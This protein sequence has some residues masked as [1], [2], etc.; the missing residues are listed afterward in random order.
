MEKIAI[1]LLPLEII[2]KERHSAKLIFVNK[3][4][5][6]ILLSLVFL[7]SSMLALRILQNSQLKAASDNLALA[8]NRVLNLKDKEGYVITLKSRLNLIQSLLG[9]SK[10]ESAFNLI[11]GLVPPGVNPNQISVDKS[12]NIILSLQTNSLEALDKFILDLS[13][14]QKN[15]NLVIRVDLESFSRGKE[16]IYRCSLKVQIK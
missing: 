10:K 7:T 11:S 12:G 9:D 2:I 3:V 5:V 8:S 14:P 4:S 1:N 6:V 16:G 15:S 13:N